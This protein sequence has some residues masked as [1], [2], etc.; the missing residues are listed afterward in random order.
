MKTFVIS[1]EQQAANW[2][3]NRMRR[4]KRCHPVKGGLELDLLDGVISELQEEYERL[5]AGYRKI[6]SQHENAVRNAKELENRHSEMDSRTYRKRW[7][8]LYEEEIALQELG[9]T[10]RHYAEKIRQQREAVWFMR[11]MLIKKSC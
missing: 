3:G 11:E 2:N 9:A 5:Y 1:R 7:R 6:H 10:V 4:V 8:G